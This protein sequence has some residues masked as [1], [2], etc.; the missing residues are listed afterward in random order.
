MMAAKA[1]ST[2]K[3]LG[4]LVGIDD[5]RLADIVISGIQIDS[6]KVT[7]GDLFIAIKGHSVDGRQFISQAVSAGAAAVI[8]DADE[9][10]PENTVYKSVPVIVVNKLSA[11]LGEIAS[12]FFDRPSQRLPVIA[13]TGTNGKTSCTQ[14]M[15]QILNGLGKSCG[16]MGTLGIGVDGDFNEATNTT[17][18]AVTIQR[19]LQQWVEGK[20]DTAVMEVSSHGIAQGRVDALQ[21]E[22]ALFTNLSRDHLD[23]HGSMQAYAETK[24][25]LFSWPGLKKAV[26]NMDDDFSE[27]LLASVASDVEVYTFSIKSQ[28]KAD[29]FVDKISYHRKGVSSVLHS[30]WGVF[31]FTYPL[32]GEFNLSN[33]LAVVTCLGVLG[34]SLPSVVSTLTGLATIPGRM[35]L[36]SNASDVTVVVDYAHTPDALE[37]ALKAM[38]LHACGKLWCVFGCGGDRDQGKRSLMGAVAQ[39]Y[40]DYVV[41][42]SDNPRSESASHIIDEI[43]SMV[44]RPALIEEDRAKAINFAIKQAGVG[45]S[46][47]I[48]GKGHEDYQQI[49]ENKL[50][51]SDIHQA[52]L[53]LLARI[54]EQCQ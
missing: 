34:Y 40:S 54:K 24:A 12:S 3:R 26:I 10:W 48:A 25:Q 32:M 4:D 18:D 39:Q 11:E 49:G 50:P 37:Q 14:L 21:F 13:V 41:V 6:R 17:P 43:I 28:S 9:K 45:D 31:P 22:L 47:L 36:V 35:E 1:L 5:Q 23:Y 19:Y 51:F 7:T 2:I 8:A 33:V 52:R 42:T 44:D 46:I 38:S 29:I 16:V 53:G 30:P 15:M 27:Q 20:T